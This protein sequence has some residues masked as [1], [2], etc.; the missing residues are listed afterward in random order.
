MNQQSDMVR[1]P[2]NTRARF[3]ERSIADQNFKFG[4]NYRYIVRAVSLGTG[5][6]QVESLNSNSLSVSTARHISAFS[7][8]SITVA[9]APGRLSIFFP[10]KSGRRYRRLQHL[11][12]DR[13]G[14]AEGPMDKLN[15]ALLD[16][17]YFP[18][19]QG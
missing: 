8:A 15:Q 5:G 14:S 16:A 13:S 9:A 12:L 6:A 17:H 1:Q 10:G 18:G 4:E 11:S 3:R 19:R 7:A 2:L